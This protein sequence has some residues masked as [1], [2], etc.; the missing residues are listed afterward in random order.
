MPDWVE[1]VGEATG[2]K[3]VDLTID[4]LAGPLMNGNLK[5]TR[6]GGRIINVGRMAGNSGELDFDLHSMRRI[7]YVGVTFRTRSMAEVLDVIRKT[8]AA[9]GGALAAGK[10]RVPIDRKFL[11]EDAAV[12]YEHMA[13]NRHFGK[14]VVTTI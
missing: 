13:R 2:G 8:E 10:L 4:F 14:I 6:I 1:K 7:E 9:L 5:A 12:A 11:L 3:G